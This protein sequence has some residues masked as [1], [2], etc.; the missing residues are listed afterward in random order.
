MSELCLVVGAGQ[1]GLTFTQTLRERGYKGRIVMAG[2]ERH[3][4]YQ[5]PPLSKKFLSGDLTED[6]LFLK[7]PAFYDKH[8]IDLRLGLRINAIDIAH[9]HAEHD[10]GTLA[11]DHLVLATGTRAR[12]LP[13][14]GGPVPGVVVLR[15]IA[16]VEMIR[17]LLERRGRL[18]IIGAGYIGLEVAAVARALGLGV[19]VLE[20]QS[21]V[22]ARVVAEPVSAYYEALHRR[23]GVELRFGTALRDIEHHPGGL[24]AVSV[25]GERF[26]ADLVLVA[27]GARPNVELAADAGLDVH[28]GILVDAACRTSDKRVLAVGDC[29]RFPSA[30]YGRSIRL[31]SVQN[32]IDQAKAAAATLMGDSLAYDPVPWFW[33]DQFDVKLQIAGLSDGYDHAVVRGHPDENAFS[34][35]YVKGERLLAVD[36]INRARDHML[37]R[38]LIGERLRSAPESLADLATPWEQQL[39]G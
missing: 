8:E 23:H 27:I 39:A 25:E 15:S 6:R 28:D 36:S 7:P 13:L 33:S 29:T 1:A 4:P 30:R 38:R 14:A 12:T 18:V 3:L 16:D 34:V 31:E 26:P 17:P 10:G 19:T 2:E 11:F 24:V 9:G 37:A 35:F 22:M 21:R 20:A 32:A 5:R